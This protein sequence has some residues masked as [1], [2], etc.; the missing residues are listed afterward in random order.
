M[1]KRKQHQGKKVLYIFIY[2][3]IYIYTYMYQFI[4]F[5]L[6]WNDT[7][8]VSDG[9]SVAWQQL[10]DFWGWDA[11]EVQLRCPY[12]VSGDIRGGSARR[13]L[14]PKFYQSTQTMVT[15]GILPVRENSNRSTGNRNRDLMIS[16][17][18]LWPLD[19]KAGQIR[20]QNNVH[21]TPN[22]A[23]GVTKLNSEP[24]NISH[25][26]K[27]V[28]QFFSAEELQLCFYSSLHAMLHQ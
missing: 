11:H 18:R 8:H 21:S 16:S 1:Y 2:I 15:A 27:E 19:H 28:I 22:Q 23:V 3:Y 5:I 14:K 4:K 13:G 20:I 12:D 26:G 17:P 24:T 6:F 9:L 7:L 25:E 10:T